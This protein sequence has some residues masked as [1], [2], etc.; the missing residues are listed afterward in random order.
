MIKPWEILDTEYIVNNRWLKLSSKKFLLPN[1]TIV[2]DYY[3]AEKP[4][5]VIIVPITPD[6]QTMIMKEFER[7]VMQVG[8]KF[9]AGRVNEKE[10]PDKAAIRE[11]M[12]ETGILIEELIP[13][14]VLDA[15][16]GWMTTKVYIFVAKSLSV[17]TEPFPDPEELYETEWIPFK[18]LG[19]MIKEGKVHNIFVVSAYHLAEKYI[20][21]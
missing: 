3:I 7:G 18:E 14:G 6:G 10:K 15:E 19:H 1:G 5:I 11:F 4:D 8:Y 13:V 2:P 9:P 12:E 16:P 20:G 21:A 17:T